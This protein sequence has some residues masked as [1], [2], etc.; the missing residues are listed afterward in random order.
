RCRGRRLRGFSGAA[1]NR[2]KFRREGWSFSHGIARNR[3]C[4]SAH[5]IAK[6]RIPNEELRM[7]ETVGAG[8]PVFFIRNSEFESSQFR[9]Q[10]QGT[11]AAGR[12]RTGRRDAGVT[13]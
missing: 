1:R 7:R 13:R 12:R 2:W 3:E 9:G 10:K 5:G 4:A 6:I 11:V 8:A